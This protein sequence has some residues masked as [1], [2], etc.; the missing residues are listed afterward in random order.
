MNNFEFYNPVKICFGKGEIA[1]LSNLVPKNEKILI[2]Y[3]GGS[4]KRN[5]VYDQVMAALKGYD[6]TEFLGIEANPHYETL[7]KAVGIV[8]EKKISFLLAVGGGSVL[9]GQNLFQQ[10][11]GGGETIPGI[12]F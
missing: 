6:V 3:G 7:M 5:V 10:L 11:P 1:K 9:D 8:R 12:F 4:I 2:T